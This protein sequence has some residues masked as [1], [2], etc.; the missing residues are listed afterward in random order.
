MK[1][2]TYRGFA[3][4]AEYSGEDGCLVGHVEG[5]SDIIGFHGESEEEAEANFQNVIDNYLDCCAEI[6]KAPQCN[7]PWLHKPDDPE[8]GPADPE[9]HPS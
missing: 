7:V 9:I 2:L 3:A 1:T 4:K 5:I 8:A 6:G